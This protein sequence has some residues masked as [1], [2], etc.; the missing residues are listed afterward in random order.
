VSIEELADVLQRY[1]FE[2]IEDLYPAI[3]FGKIMP[4]SILIALFPDLEPPAE[5]K[6]QQS[7]IAGVVRKVLGKGDTPIAVQGQDGLLVYLAK[8]C[9]PIPGDEIVGYITRG[10]GISV[11]T[12]DC[13]NVPSFTPDRITE[14][15]WVNVQ[16]NEVFPVRLAIAIED[17]QGILAEITSAISNLKTNI[18][19]SRS[20]ADGS[21]GTVEVTIDISDLKHLHKVVQVLKG[22]RGI[23]DVERIRA[24]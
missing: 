10:K 13:S 18:R 1:S 24:L 19:E 4:R 12:T 11:H 6:A 5:A 2:K 14:V 16:E 15:A 20:S 3:G 7:G 22:I 9:N 21:Q 23:R 8:C 17:R